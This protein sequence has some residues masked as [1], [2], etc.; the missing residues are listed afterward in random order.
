M[1]EIPRQNR[2][3]SRSFANNSGRRG[4][5]R[6]VPEEGTFW[7]FVRMPPNVRRRSERAHRC[8]GNC[9]RRRAAPC[10]SCC[11]HAHDSPLVAYASRVDFVS[12]YCNQ[13]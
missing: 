11:C 10:H 5:L 12:E 9:S 7:D 13:R 6:L 1:F 2:E 8:Y 4:R 3:L